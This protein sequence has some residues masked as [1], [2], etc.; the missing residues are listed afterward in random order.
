MADQPNSLAEG[1][2]ILWLGHHGISPK[3]FPLDLPG[4]GPD[5]STSWVI[6]RGENMGKVYSFRSRVYKGEC[7]H[8]PLSRRMRGIGGQSIKPGEKKREEKKNYTG[9]EDTPRIN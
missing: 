8:V 3:G 5:Q 7:S 6:P 9:S 4:E 1:P 2:P